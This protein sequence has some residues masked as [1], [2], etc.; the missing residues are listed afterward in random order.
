[1]QVGVVFAGSTSH[2]ILACHPSRR[3]C[4][5]LEVR[6]KGDG[7][8]QSCTSRLLREHRQEQATTSGEEVNN[9]SIFSR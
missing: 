4:R 5:R 2:G 7:G 9:Q 6:A 8:R 3:G 1:M